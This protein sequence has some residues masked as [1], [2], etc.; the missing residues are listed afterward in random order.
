M[1]K[2]GR[3][4]ERGREGERERGREGRLHL[5]LL[6]GLFTSFSQTLQE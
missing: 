5:K 1:S 3:E 6:E 2:R 4:E